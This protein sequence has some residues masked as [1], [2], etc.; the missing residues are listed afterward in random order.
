VRDAFAI[1]AEGN[2][3]SARQASEALTGV[4]RDQALAGVAMQWAKS[5]LDAAIAW[6][7]RLPDGTDRDEIIR[8]ALLGKAAVDPVTALDRVGS[9]PSAEGTPTLPAPRARACCLPPPRLI[10]TP[11]LT[12]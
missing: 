1:V 4:S 12:G 5:D 7:K 10:L 9:V 3:T 6:A 2:L 8:T 11:R